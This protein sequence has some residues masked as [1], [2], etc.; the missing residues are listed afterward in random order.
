MMNSLT[1]TLAVGLP[2]AF[3]TTIMMVVAA[4]AQSFQV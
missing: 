2:I 4:Q 1:R 3:L